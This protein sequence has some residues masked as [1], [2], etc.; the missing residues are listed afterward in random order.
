MSELTPAAVI[1]RV[2]L[3]ISA[4]AATMSLLCLAHVNFGPEP[5][6]IV[7]GSSLCAA[8]TLLWAF[9]RLIITKGRDRLL[10]LTCVVLS[11]IPLAIFTY[12]WIQMNGE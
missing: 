2:L 5:L 10:T 7:L 11:L 3:V 8:V 1:T 6:T 9:G 4:I 12:A